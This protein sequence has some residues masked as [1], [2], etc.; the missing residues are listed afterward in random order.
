MD[1]EAAGATLAVTESPASL[2]RSYLSDELA[3]P[4]SEGS[5]DAFFFGLA[6]HLLLRRS[7]AIRTTIAAAATTTTIAGDRRISRR[8]STVTNWALDDQPSA[9]LSRDRRKAIA[10]IHRR[11]VCVGLPQEP[12]NSCLSRDDKESGYSSG[13]SAHTMWQ[14]KNRP[15]ANRCFHP[16]CVACCTSRMKRS[17][18]GHA[19]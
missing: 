11:V 19:T 12:L 17:H 6:R 4:G 14:I 9:E 3:N 1:I 8:S 10:E 18:G 13:V 5:C 2:H 7:S 16:L 15:K